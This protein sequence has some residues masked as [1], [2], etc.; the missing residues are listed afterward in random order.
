MC[1][2][3]NCDTSE[4][5]ANPNTRDL[6]RELMKEVYSVAERHLNRGGNIVFPPEGSLTIDDYLT[7]S[8]LIGHYRYLFCLTS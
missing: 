1:T 7:R 8:E 6:L 4:V 5:L 2:L 3:T